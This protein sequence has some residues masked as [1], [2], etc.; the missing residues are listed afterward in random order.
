M[1]NS[2]RKGYRKRVCHIT[3]FEEPDYLM[4]KVGGRWMLKD[5]ARM[6]KRSDAVKNR[7]P[8]PVITRRTDG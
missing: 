8:F 7:K 5:V 6:K 2:Y 1:K 3:G 4:A